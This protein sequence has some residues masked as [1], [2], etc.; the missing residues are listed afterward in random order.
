MAKTV[1][2]P[3]KRM[4]P[5]FLTANNDGYVLIKV[6][7]RKVTPIEIEEVSCCRDTK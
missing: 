2:S 4:P 5:R 7:R 6:V 1:K 3:A